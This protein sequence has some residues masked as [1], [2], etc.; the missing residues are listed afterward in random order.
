[1]HHDDTGLIVYSEQPEKFKNKE[2]LTQ[3]H[4]RYYL[5]GSWSRCSL[6]TALC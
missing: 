4:F 3:S 1:M 5:P 6:G 2:I